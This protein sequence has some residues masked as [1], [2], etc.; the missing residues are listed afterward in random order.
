MGQ[1]GSGRRRR[2]ERIDVLGRLLFRWRLLVPASE[3]AGLLPFERSEVVAG[4][5]SFGGDEAAMR[6]AEPARPLPEGAV[7][8]LAFERVWPSEVER[9]W[10]R[11][12]ETAD[13]DGWLVGRVDCEPYRLRRPRFGDVVVFTERHVVERQPGM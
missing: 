12:V 8:K 1:I 9:L 7:V 11:V 6:R 13:V 4:D 3:A 10:V 2:G 5:E